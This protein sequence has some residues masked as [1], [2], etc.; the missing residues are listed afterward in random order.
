MTQLLAEWHRLYHPNPGAA[1]LPPL[2]SNGLTRL[3]LLELRQPAD[4]GLL[5]AVWQAVQTELGLPAPAIAVNGADGY[6]L[7]FSLAKPVDTAQAQAFWQGLL[8]RYLAGTPH[9]RLRCWPALDVPAET[10]DPNQPQTTSQPPWPQVPAE[11]AHAGRWSAFVAPDLARIFGDE[12]W[13]DVA[14]GQAAQAALLAGL[15]STPLPAFQAALAQLVTAR[16][17]TAQPAQQTYA[18]ELTPAAHAA[19]ATHADPVTQQA[20]TTLANAPQDPQGF[21]LAVMNDPQVPLAL[22][23]EAAKALLPLTR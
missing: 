3:V 7:W 9:Q 2:A 15:A 22:R 1:S 10:A 4:W 16:Q 19:H 21:L 5:G 6:Q 11:Q 8:A 13:L 20:E 23:V 12:P 14:P 17:A 18:A